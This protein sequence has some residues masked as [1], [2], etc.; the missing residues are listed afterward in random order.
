MTMLS[1]ACDSLQTIKASVALQA[2][3]HLQQKAGLQCRHAR[4]L[5]GRRALC[6]T[7]GHAKGL[8][9]HTRAILE[10]HAVCLQLAP[11]IE[12]QCQ[13]TLHCKRRQL[14]LCMPQSVISAVRVMGCITQ[15]QTHTQGDAKQQLLLLVEEVRVGLVDVCEGRALSDA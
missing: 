8:S 9:E 14:H 11:A 6:R 4:H 12:L 1:R 2:S 13:R 3:P 5:D 10:Q 7:R 15:Q